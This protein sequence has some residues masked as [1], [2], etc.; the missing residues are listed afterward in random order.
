MS[1]T[2]LA[3]VVALVLGHVAPTLVAGLRQYGW[4]AHWTGWLGRQAQGWEFWRGRYG[5]VLALLPPLL[6]V[7]LV[8]WVWRLPW[9][10]LFDLLFGVVALVYAW[11]PRDLDVDVEAIIDSDDPEARR[12]AIADLWPSDAQPSSEGPALVEAVFRSALQR[13]FGVVFWFL[14]LGPAGALLYRLAE[15]AA[16]HGETYGLPEANAAGARV[17]R[18]LLEWP[19]AQLM[20]WSMALVGNF[21]VVYQAWRS[22]GGNRLQLDSGFLGAAARASV[23][24]ELAE[25]AQEY[26]EEGMVQVLPELPELRD[27]MSL[28]W[29]VLLL[30]LAVLAVLVIAGWVS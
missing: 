4:F 29:R 17:L 7:G 20:T 11:G 16:Q 9:M 21:D 2:L 26:A 1:I 5:I 12:I 14:L 10:G 8:Q 27:A 15:L 18:A 28:A 23:R 19:V 30:W 22:N 3:V 24:S 13:W 25:E 6:L